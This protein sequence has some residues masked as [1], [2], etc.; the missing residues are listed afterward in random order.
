MTR[1]TPL[2]IDVLRKLA[3]KPRWHHKD[4]L[5]EVMALTKKGLVINDH[6]DRSGD[7]LCFEITDAGRVALKELE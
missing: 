4:F 2:Q 5:Q 7:Y 3:R 6:M 1:L